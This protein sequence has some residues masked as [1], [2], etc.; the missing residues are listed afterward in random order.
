M[1]MVL[2]SI[3]QKQETTHDAKRHA[4]NELVTDK[5]T[6]HKD[7]NTNAWK[8]LLDRP[9]YGLNN[10]LTIQ[11]GYKKDVTTQRN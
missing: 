5:H 6:I 2:K 1:L 7:I 3:L 9:E 10:N 4:T 11:N 8:I